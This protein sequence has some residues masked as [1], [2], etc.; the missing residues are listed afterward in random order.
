[1]KNIVQSIIKNT[2]T[3]KLFVHLR[4]PWKK[5]YPL[6]FGL[7]AGGH[8]EINETLREG[9]KR[10]IREKLNINN[11]NPKYLFSF[12]FGKNQKDH[13]YYLEYNKP[14]K[15]NCDEFIWTGWYTINQVKQLDN[16]NFL[17]PD[18]AVAFNKFINKNK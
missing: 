9:M 17:C 3:N 7:G 11:S 13:I 16:K 6:K 5:T 14:I 15:T 10:E 2:K 12:P 8:A 18:T 4:S 1:M